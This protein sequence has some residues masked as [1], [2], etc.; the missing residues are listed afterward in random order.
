MEKDEL[1][2]VKLEKG[3]TYPSLL[4]GEEIIYET[5]GSAPG[6]MKVLG[7]FDEGYYNVMAL[8]YLGPSLEDL[9]EFCERQ[10]SLKTTLMLIDQIL[11]R[12]GHFHSKGIVHRDLK[13]ANILMGRGKSGNVVY[14]AD[15]GISGKFD[16]SFAAKFETDPNVKHKLGFMGSQSFAP[17]RSHQHRRKLPPLTDFFR[18][19]TFPKIN[20]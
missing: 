12:V 7:R 5:I 11:C 15:F 13:P 10:F 6:F 4:S 17:I 8:E 1:I 2:V 18:V 9:M 3:N 16:A 20:R 19:L 14:I